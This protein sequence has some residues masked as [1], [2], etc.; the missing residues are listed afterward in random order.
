MDSSVRVIELR[1]IAFSE[2]SFDFKRYKNKMMSL[3]DP[4][5][6]FFFTLKN[7]SEL[8]ASDPCCAVLH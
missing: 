6:F 2:S 8:S 1:Y 3:T 7:S 4:V 5:F